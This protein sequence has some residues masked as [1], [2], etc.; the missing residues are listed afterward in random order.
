MT[1]LA[2]TYLGLSLRHPVLASA[3]PLSRSLDGIRELEDAGAAAIVLFS[4]FEEQ[5]RLENAA[6]AHL[7]GDGAEGFPEALDYLPSLADR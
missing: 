1:D 4:L 3:G 5:I 7:I 2:T 6:T